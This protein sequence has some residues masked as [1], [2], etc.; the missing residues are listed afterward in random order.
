MDLLWKV[1]RNY[2]DN[3]EIRNYRYTMDVDDGFWCIWEILLAN[4]S[5]V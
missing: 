3:A 2:W 5:V 1:S 4:P